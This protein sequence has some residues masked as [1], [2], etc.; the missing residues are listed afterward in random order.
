LH[1]PKAAAAAPAPAAA[2]AAKPAAPAS[3]GTA[4]G[5]SSGNRRQMFVTLNGQRHNVTVETI[6]E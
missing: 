5:S 4:V 2:P 3:T 1:K 6:Q